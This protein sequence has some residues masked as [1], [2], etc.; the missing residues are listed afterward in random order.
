[1][2]RFL[3]VLVILFGIFGCGCE[4]RDTIDAKMNGMILTD[5]DG[6]KW[7]A[8]HRIGDSYVLYNIKGDRVNWLGEK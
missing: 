7:I 5:A 4:S 6:N 1:M 8:K 2:K 3:L